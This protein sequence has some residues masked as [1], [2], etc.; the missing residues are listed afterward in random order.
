MKAAGLR[1]K[2]LVGKEQAENKENVQP[3]TQAGKKQ[4][5]TSEEPSKQNVL[6]GA[7]T[8]PAKKQ[9][10]SRKSAP[11]AS[12]LRVDLTGEDATPIAPVRQ[13]NLR[14][15]SSLPAAA[16]RLI[17]SSLPTRNVPSS[18]R[19]RGADQ[20][21]TF[22]ELPGEVLK[23][24]CQK[25]DPASVLA[26]RCVGP[27]MRDAC[28]VAEV[29]L[30][31]T[32]PMQAMGWS[33]AQIKAWERRIKG[34]ATL[35]AE[36]RMTSRSL[37]LRMEGAEAWRDSEY[38]LPAQ[39]ESASSRL[40]ALLGRELPGLCR[41]DAASPIRHA[42][43]ELPITTEVLAALAAA[44][45][46]DL[47]SLRLT[48]LV[49]APHNHAALLAEAPAFRR[50]RK[51]DI[52]VTAWDQVQCLN[53]LRDLKDLNLRY[54]LW[55][56]PE[57]SSLSS[58]QQLETFGLQ[59]E[60]DRA[61]F[62]LDFL[63]PLVKNHH[64][65]RNVKA[66]VIL[67]RTAV[68]EAG[69]ASLE[70]LE[71]CSLH[72]LELDL[73]VPP[74]AAR[75]V[76][77][78][79]RDLHR[80]PWWCKLHVTIRADALTREASYDSSASATGPITGP[81]LG[82]ALPMPAA[83]AAAAGS[84]ASTAEAKERLERWSCLNLP[85][86]EHPEDALT[87]HLRGYRRRLAVLPDLSA[88]N[89]SRL[90]ISNATLSAADFALLGECRCLQHLWLRFS[91]LPDRDA[92][93]TNTATT[94]GAAAG[95]GAPSSAAGGSG[96]RA[97]GSNPVDADP[98]TST[99]AHCRA[100]VAAAQQPWPL[101]Y[102]PGCAARRAS[103]AP[104]GPAA[105]TR[106]RKS[107]GSTGGP[108]GA[109]TAAAAAAAGGAAP[110]AGG[111]AAPL[112]APAPAPRRRSSSAAGGAGASG[113]N[114][115]DCSEAVAPYVLRPLL[116]L[117]M[118][119]SLEIVEERAPAPEQPLPPLLPPE[120]PAARLR[121]LRAGGGNGPAAVLPP[122]PSSAVVAAA[123]GSR[124]QRPAAAAAA[125]AAPAAAAPQP[126]PLS[127]VSLRHFLSQ[128]N[129]MD[130]LGGGGGG[131]VSI[132]LL[133]EEAS[134]PDCPCAG[135]QCLNG[136]GRRRRRPAELDAEAILGLLSGVGCCRVALGA[137]VAVGRD[138]RRPSAWPAEE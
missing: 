11:E 41:A 13:Y 69:P 57:L 72:R 134:L 137:V 111:A 114:G 29:E 1:G 94:S 84:G 108:A 44:F 76:H 58:L 127:R 63:G 26:A 109:G 64:T 40:V 42:D 119:E 70:F 23:I 104:N 7:Q 51:L 4:K 2:R 110:A 71:G 74:D 75:T 133:S 88:A 92:T 28:S 82:C 54:K 125:A 34:L 103:D 90:Q 96:S 62:Q 30:R 123:G 86:D 45:G 79:F 107:L 78:H 121:P 106:A 33:P 52:C 32:M 80:T 50:L 39:V 20:R 46:P 31:V 93:N 19:P 67:S 89:L 9:R 132:S 98:A 56:I 43:V 85:V 36:G 128:L 15:R 5:R 17:D 38:M 16:A 77:A 68:G 129:K 81:R 35:L 18:V 112:V 124:Q 55:N 95:R 61:R 66:S 117:R 113:G 130:E 21:A 73:R 14:S 6:D 136:E 27:T 49:P 115:P 138:W 25:L 97:S 126:M 105:G 24:I 37:A 48:S 53:G 102:I 120:Q 135:R 10:A 83:A 131:A 22:G 118:L 91:Y 87:L 12:M 59:V 122:A 8:Q 47:D 99:S 3:A 60:D 101:D 100:I 65:L 116:Q